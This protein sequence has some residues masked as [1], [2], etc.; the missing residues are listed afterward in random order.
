MT[1]IRCT[2]GSTVGGLLLGPAVVSL[3]AIRAY[4]TDDQVARAKQLEANVIGD[5]TKALSCKSFPILKEGN[6]YCHTEYRGLKVEFAGVNAPN[7][8]AV[9]VTSMGP[10]QRLTNLGRRCLLVE[11]SDADLQLSG[12]GTGIIMRDDGVLSGNY[13]NDPARAACR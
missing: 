5:M 9:Y 3:M 12:V 10:N 13:A 1:T 2:L 7:G 8:G 4:G 11:F 6:L